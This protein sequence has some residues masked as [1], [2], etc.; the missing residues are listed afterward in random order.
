ML[1]KKTYV[2]HKKLC[3]QAWANCAPHADRARSGE[4]KFWGALDFSGAHIK[5]LKQ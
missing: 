4:K 2:K 5:L 3:F 1:H